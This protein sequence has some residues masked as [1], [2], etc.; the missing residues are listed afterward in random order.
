MKIES[1]G[2]FASGK[3]PSVEVGVRLETTAGI[4]VDLGKGSCEAPIIQL[5]L[6]V[7][8]NEE[9]CVVARLSEAAARDLAAG[10]VFE[11][12]RHKEIT[13]Q[14]SEGFTPDDWDAE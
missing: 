1:E 12:E 5:S 4:G 11:I 10:I 9:P 8:G 13:A 7:L 14:V 6:T 2:Y 3:A